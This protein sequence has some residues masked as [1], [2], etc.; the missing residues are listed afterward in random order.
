MPIRLHSLIIT[1][2]VSTSPDSAVR[3]ADIYIAG[4]FA[5]RYAVI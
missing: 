4:K 5:L 1:P 2:M 3:T